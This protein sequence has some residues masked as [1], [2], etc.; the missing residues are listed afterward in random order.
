[1]TAVMQKIQEDAKKK[2]DE[3]WERKR[4]VQVKKIK[5]N[6]I[7]DKVSRIKK[8]DNLDPGLGNPGRFLRC[9]IGIVKS[10]KFC[11]FLLLKLDQAKKNILLTLNLGVCKIYITLFS[12]IMP[13][14]C[15]PYVIAVHN[16]NKKWVKFIYS[17]KATKFCE[18]ST[19]DLSYVVCTVKICGGYF[20]KFWGL[21]RIYELYMHIH[22]MI[23]I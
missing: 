16:N 17:E 11:Y 12:K 9:L 2:E 18:I 4:E 14:F 3:K 13:N 22:F 23:R 10:L 1:M 6:G 15:R 5:E 7:Y 8:T 20:S 19:V 21:P